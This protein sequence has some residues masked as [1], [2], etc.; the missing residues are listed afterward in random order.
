[1]KT[2]QLILTIVVA[3][4]T[5]SPVMAQSR[6][7]KIVDE[8]E[9]KGVDAKKVVKRDP[10]TKKPYSIVKSLTFYSKD[11]NYANRLKEAFR[12]DA[13]DAIEEKVERKGNSYRL[14]FVDGKKRSTYS[15]DIQER[16]EKEPR[17]DLRIV[18]RDGNVKELDI[19]EGLMDNFGSRVI[20]RREWKG[21]DGQGIIDWGQYGNNLTDADV[22][23]IIEK[24]V[25]SGT[26][27]SEI[28]TE[29]LQRGILISQIRAMDEAVK[30]KMNKQEAEKKAKEKA[31]KKAY[32]KRKLWRNQRTRLDKSLS[33]NTLTSVK[34]CKNYVT[35]GLFRYTANV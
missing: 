12:K 11:S 29:L 19:F 7:D 10:N 31:A 9:Q 1:M 35:V 25:L 4:I 30:K 33:Q 16:Q 18:I 6:I 26:S 20:E 15:L 23:E 34:T 17:V 8:L 32:W 24:G 21:L 5:C 13:E 28:T 14:V 27:L 2:R 22:Y 3:L